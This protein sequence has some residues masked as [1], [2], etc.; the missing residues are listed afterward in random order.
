PTDVCKRW[1]QQSALVNGTLYLYGGQSSTTSD[2]T[3]NTWNNNFLALDLT[4]TWQ[5]SSPSLTG[6]P[7]PSGPPPVAN[8]YLWNSFDALYLYGG[9]FADNPV[10]SPVAFSL[11]EYNIQSSSWNSYDNPVTTAGQNS[12]PAGAAIQRA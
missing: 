2:Q 6:L 1:S 9:E 5:I 4:R 7:Q 10:T 3:S 8:G 11:W 12:E